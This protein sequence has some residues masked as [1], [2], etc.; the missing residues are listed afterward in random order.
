MARN[1]NNKQ[2]VWLPPP[3]KNLMTVSGITDYLTVS[4]GSLPYVEKTGPNVATKEAKK[5]ARE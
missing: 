2:G 5:K 1:E 3:S 4:D